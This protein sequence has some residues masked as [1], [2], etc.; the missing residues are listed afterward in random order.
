MTDISI[1]RDGLSLAASVYGP[2]E[3]EP[4][5][6]LHGLSQSRDTWNEIVQR[7][8]DRYQV[9]T[10][11]F[12]G[13]GHSD[14]ASRYVFQDYVADAEAVVKLLKRPPVVVGHSLGACVSGVLAQSGAI[15]GAFLEDPP[16]FLGEEAEWKRSVYPTIFPIVAAQQRKLQQENAP[17]DTFLAFVSNT[18]SLKGGIAG[19]HIGPRHLL[20]HASALQRQDNRCWEAVGAMLAP[21]ARE[22][23]FRCPAKILQSDATLGAALLDGH[24]LR[25]AATNPQVEIVRYDGATHNIH[26]E[27]AFEDRFFAD[28][29]AFLSRLTS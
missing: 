26:R 22:R 11:D 6:F 7:L 2:Q 25:L 10:L 19:D 16:W 29:T 9:W 28:L 8:C 12:H 17:L 4:V 3:A 23:A 14:R 5:L 1:Q 24:E 15:R 13:H 27:R 18:P 20:S 21:I